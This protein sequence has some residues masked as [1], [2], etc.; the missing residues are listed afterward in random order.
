MKINI[1]QAQNNNVKS[2]LVGNFYR[3]PSYKISSFHEYVESILSSLD[4]HGNKNITYGGDFNVDLCKYGHDSDCQALIDCSARHNFVQLINRP[5]R[6]TEYSATI[7]DHI[8]TNK[9][10]DVVSTGVVTFDISDHLGVY[11]TI[12]L[13]EHQGSIDHEYANVTSTHKVNE[14]NISK[15]R[16]L[17][18]NESWDEVHNECGAQRKY[19]KFTEIYN[20]QLCRNLQKNENMSEKFQNSGFFFGSRMHVHGRINYIIFL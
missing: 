5:T 13:H 3:S 10:S 20:M 1:K 16:E 14:E 7:I 19:D 6:V 9:V 17:L 18:S 12:A 11:V 8:Y 2:Y 4:K 15:F